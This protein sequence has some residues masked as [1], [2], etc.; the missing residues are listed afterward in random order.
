MPAQRNPS[1]PD[2]HRVLGVPRDATPAE[3]RT[4]YRALLLAFHPDT[5]AEPTDP[6]LLAQVVAAH[7]QLRDACY[8]D[9]SEPAPPTGTTPPGASGVPIPVRVRSPRR[10]RPDIR[11]GPVRS[12]RIR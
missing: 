11:V 4:A 5:R 7:A 1:S 9:T 3:I 2:P 6:A 10:E 8:R 12:H